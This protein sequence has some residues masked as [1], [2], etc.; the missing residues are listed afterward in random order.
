MKAK[1][2]FRSNYAEVKTQH[3]GPFDNCVCIPLT[4]GMHGLVDT[5]DF[6]LL[7]DFYWGAHGG[8]RGDPYVCR[9]MAKNGKQVHVRLHRLILVT[10]RPA[11]DHKNGNTLDNR[12]DNLRACTDSQNNYNQSRRSDAPSQY[13]GITFRTKEKVWHAQIQTPTVRII[14]AF[15]ATALEA[16]IEYDKLAIK[17]FGEFARTNFPRENYDVRPR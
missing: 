8:Y 15:K 2:F 6:H 11:V 9:N 10:D 14:S 12:K 1:S 17:H 4:K 7:G 13:R 16:A 5:D 3:E